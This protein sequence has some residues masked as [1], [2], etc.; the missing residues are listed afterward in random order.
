MTVMFKGLVCPIHSIVDGA[1]QSPNKVKNPLLDVGTQTLLTP[2]SETLIPPMRVYVSVF[3][4]S[5]RSCV[6][7]SNFPCVLRTRMIQPR[8]LGTK[9]H[10]RRTLPPNSPFCRPMEPETLRPTS[11]PRSLKGI[12]AC[13]L[14]D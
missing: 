14:S 10:M 4:P 12:M 2:T 7:M 6:L 11:T 5:S 8:F 1:S 13:P 3:M 9:L